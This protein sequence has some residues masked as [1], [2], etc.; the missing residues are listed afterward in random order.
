[1]DNTSPKD[2]VCVSVGVI[3]S[4]SVL[5]FGMQH[6]RHLHKRFNDGLKVSWIWGFYTPYILGGW[7]MSLAM[8]S[9]DELY[10][11]NLGHWDMNQN[12]QAHIICNELPKMMFKRQSC[13]YGHFLTNTLGK[14][15][16]SLIP[17]SNHRL[18]SIAAILLQGWLWQ[19][20]THKSWF[21]IR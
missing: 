14:G 16:E 21:A 11:W 9:G 4:P 6:I 17:P 10:I 8:E 18:N 3:F 7:P 5:D 19:W 20:I 2:Y 15:M 13:Y 12:F 1:M